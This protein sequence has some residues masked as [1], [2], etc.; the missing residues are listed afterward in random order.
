MDNNFKLY[1][2]DF[3]KMNNEWSEIEYDEQGIYNHPT[4]S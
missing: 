1:L 2:T 3:T 4:Y